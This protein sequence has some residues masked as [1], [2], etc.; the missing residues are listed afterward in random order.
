M[1]DLFNNVILI[2]AAVAWFAAQL[3]KMGIYCWQNKEV[4]LVSFFF[5]TGGMPSS[6]SATVTALATITLFVCGADSP[7]FAITL[8][9]AVIVMRDASGVRLETGKQAELLNMI[10]NQD[11]WVLKEGET[12]PD[13]FKESI[14]HTPTQVFFGGLLGVIIGLIAGLN[15]A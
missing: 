8:I 11:F 10:L 13:K 15:F 5:A 14:G 2:T 6:H 4:G 1:S 12:L 3:I 7:E 9:L